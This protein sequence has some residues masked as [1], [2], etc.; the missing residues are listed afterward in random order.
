M[1]AVRKQTIA[2]V[3]LGAGV[4]AASAAHAQTPPPG[5]FPETA[6]AAARTAAEQAA[7]APGRWRRSARAPSRWA[8]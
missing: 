8:P 7:K 6:A 5:S 4:L 3:F 1:I 2:R